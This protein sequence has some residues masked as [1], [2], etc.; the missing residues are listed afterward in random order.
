MTSTEYEHWMRL[1]LKL[2][3]KAKQKNEV[4]VG[5]LVVKNNSI[6]ST[7][8]NLKE[9]TQSPLAHAESLALHKAAK[10]LG[11]WR[12]TGCSLYVTLEPCIMCAGIILASRIDNLIYGAPDPK[13]GAVESLYNL[14]NDSRL[15][16]QVSVFPHILKDE[17]SEILT[18][19]FQNLRKKNKEQ[20]GNR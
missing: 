18:S 7:A 6:I 12:L 19:F 9:Q 5:A 14:L 4:P 13:S 10:K 2:A 3:H 15:N 8:Y 1:A 20:I 16:H 11:S 17:C